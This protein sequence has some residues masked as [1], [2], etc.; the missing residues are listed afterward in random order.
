[1]VGSMT[2]AVA[3]AE[4]DIYSTITNSQ[5]QEL[6]GLDVNVAN[7]GAFLAKR[8]KKTNVA[9]YGTCFEPEIISCKACEDNVH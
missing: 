6:D 8:I 1:M 5:R 4:N 7:Q 2:L 3:Y 9:I